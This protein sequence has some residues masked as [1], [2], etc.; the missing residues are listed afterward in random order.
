[1]VQGK[2]WKKSIGEK[3]E[4]RRW[5]INFHWHAKR[6]Q[7]NQCCW[8]EQGL[9]R[10]ARE[11]HVETRGRKRLVLPKEVLEKR[12]LVMLRHGRVVQ[13]LKA[14]MEAEPQELDRII[15][16]GEQLETLRLEI[17]PLGG[18]PKSWE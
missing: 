8:L 10:V 18:V 1:M 3:S 12:R 4:V 7:D 17:G 13:R 11:P 16:L 14:E 6:K 5:T 2:L 9:D 15:R